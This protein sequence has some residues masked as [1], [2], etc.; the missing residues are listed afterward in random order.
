MEFG[1][2]AGIS[3]RGPAGLCSTNKD[4]QEG[5]GGSRSEAHVQPSRASRCST[6]LLG[7]P[8]FRLKCGLLECY[9]LF[10]SNQEGR[11]Y[12]FES[13]L[14]SFMTFKCLHAGYVDFYLY[15]PAWGLGNIRGQ[16]VLDTRILT[17]LIQ[18]KFAHQ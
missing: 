17:F 14:A 5:N 3:T 15:I 1:I 7:A 9:N 2:Q 8:E 6:E 16:S 18:I 11:T 4:R 12:F 10:L 13:S